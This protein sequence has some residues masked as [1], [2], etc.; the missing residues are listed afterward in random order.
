[1]N[2]RLEMRRDLPGTR[3]LL[4]CGH[5]WT[6]PRGFPPEAVAADLLR[7]ESM[8]DLD[9]GLPVPETHLRWSRVALPTAEVRP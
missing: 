7:H 2:A 6:M 4:P 5:Q 9:P 1:M 3:V 8:C